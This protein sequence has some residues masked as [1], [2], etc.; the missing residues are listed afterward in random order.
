M[1]LTA[2]ILYVCLLYGLGV[3][4]T[5]KCGFK[6]NVKTQVY[7]CFY[8]YLSPHEHKLGCTLILFIMHQHYI[9]MTEWN[10]DKE[11]YFWLK[12]LHQN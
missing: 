9:P 7:Y 8:Y 1:C 6:H 2:C 10:M 5:L 4:Y 3:A 11:V 12:C